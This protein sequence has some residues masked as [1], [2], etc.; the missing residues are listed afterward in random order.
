M[1]HSAEGVDRNEEGHALP[2][3]EPARPSPAARAKAGGKRTPSGLPVQSFQTTLADLATLTRNRVQPAAGA[4][5]CR[6]ASRWARGQFTGTRPHPYPIAGAHSLT[7]AT[8]VTMIVIAVFVWGGF[9][10]V[11]SKAVRTESE[12]SEAERA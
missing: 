3:V 11:L 4:R 7:T 5:G 12:K 2:P 6:V 8:W 9:A 1:K 10:L